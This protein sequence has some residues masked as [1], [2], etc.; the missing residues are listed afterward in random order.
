MRYPRAHA[1]T[2]ILS[3]ALLLAGVLPC[4]A[5]SVSLAPSKRVVINLGETQPAWRYI[6]ADVPDA[7]F[8]STDDTKPFNDGG[9]VKNWISVGLP[10]SAEQYTTFTNETSGGFTASSNTQWY[11]KSFTMDPKYANSKVQVEFE[12]AHTGAQV[13]INGIFVPGTSTINPKATHVVGFLPFIVDLTPYLHFDGSPNLLAVRTS[14]NDSSWFEDPSFSGAFR[15]GQADSGIFRPVY[16][17]ITDRVHIPRNTYSGQGT[18]GTYVATVS[19][20]AASAVIDAQTNVVNEGTADQAVTLTTQIVDANGNIV[21]S[22]QDTKTVPANVGPGLHPQLF[23]ESLTV[24]NPILWYPNNSGY[25]KPYLYKVLHTISIGGTVY[26]A[27]QSPLGIRTITWNSDF[28]II[29]GHPHY[30]WGGSGRYDYPALGTA[31]PEEQQWRDLQ[32][33]AQAGGNLW[34]PGHSSSSPEFVAAADA[35]G[36]MIVQP[37]GD[38]ENGFA[39][40]CTPSCNKGALKKELHRDMIIRDRSNPSILAWEADNGITQEAFAAAL[41][42]LGTLW[43]PVAQ[44]VQADRTPDPQNGTILGCTVEGCEIGLKNDPKN[45]GHPTWGAEYWG[46][47][48]ARGAWDYELAFSAHFMDNWH[49]SV[50]KRAFGIVQWYFAD[51]P[52]ESNVFLEGTP[53][54]QTRSLGSSMVDQN[55]FPKLLYNVYKA[56]WTPYSIQPTV[57]LAHHWNRAGNVRVNAFSNCPYVRLLI[58]NQVQGSDQ[59]PVS[60]STGPLTDFSQNTTQIPTQVHWDVNWAPG[61]VTAQCLDV[62]H[63][64]VPNVQDSKTTAG[65]PDHIELSVVP[66]VVR[67]DGSTF[68]VT[69]N[70]SDAAFVVAKVVDSNGVVVPTATNN[71]TFTVNGPGTYA[72]GTEQ[73]MTPGK[74]VGYHSPGDPELQAEAGLTKIAIRSQFTT[75]TVTVSA[76][77]PGLNPTAASTTS[78]VIQPVAQLQPT[79]TVP[80]IIAQPVA[81]SVTVG[82]PGFFSVT[83]SGAA[84]L[85][86]QWRRNG[87]AIAGANSASYTTPN[88]STADNGAVYSVVVSNS[89]N[90]PATSAGAAL[91]VV[92]AATPVITAQPTAPANVVVGQTVALTVVASGSPTLTYQW[93]KNN[94]PIAGATSATYSTPVLTAADGGSV[95]TV[96]VTNPVNRANPLFSNPVTLSVGAAQ[97]PVITQQPANVAALPGQPATFTVGV[98]GSTPLQFV[99]KRADGT[100]VGINSPA[101]TIPAVQPS[102]IG[103]YTVTVSNIANTVTS[104]PATLSL[105][106]PGVNMALGKA[107]KASSTQDPAGLAAGFAID[108]DP[109]SR[110]GSAYTPVNTAGVDP[111]ATVDNA[112][113]FQVDLG[114]AMRFNRMVLRWDPAYASS[115]RIDVSSDG[116][117]FTPAYTQTAGAGATEDFTFPAVTA[118]Y[119][120]MQGV[121]RATQYGYSLNEMEI[122]NAPGCGGANERYSNASVATDVIDNLSSLQWSRTEYTLTA[123]GSQLTQPLAA[124][125]CANLGKRLPTVDEA[126]AISGTNS[127]SCAFPKAWNTWTSTVYPADTTQDYTVASTG[128]PATHGVATNLP[129]WALCTAGPVAAAPVITAQP[130]ATTVAAGQAATFTVAATTSG[131]APVT[132]EWR[133]NNKPVALTG[134]PSYTTPSTTAAD[135]G[136]SFSVVVTGGNGLTAS[137]NTAALTVAGSVGGGGGGTGAPVIT[138]QPANQTVAAGAAATFTVAATGTGTLSYQWLRGTTVIPGATGIAY[139][140]PATVAADNGA[141]FSV[142]VSASNNTSTTSS[143]AV[144]TIAGTSNTGAGDILAIHAGGP[145]LGG[146]LTDQDFTGGGVGAVSANTIS[147]A[148]VPFAASPA[149][150]QTAREGTFTYTIPNL[151]VGTQYTVRLHFAETW[152]TA[153]Q[154][155]VFNVAINGTVALPNFDI[156]A[157]AGAPNTANVQSLTATAVAVPN[158]TGGQIVIAFT[159]GPVDQ[160]KVDAIEVAPLTPAGPPVTPATGTVLLSINAGG[161]VIKNFVAD[162]DFTGGGVGQTATQPIKTAGVADATDPAVYQS[163]REGVFQYTFTG[164]IPDA[165]YGI[166][167]HFAET[168]FTQPKQR[169]FNVALNGTTVLP[170]FDIVADSGANTAVVKTFTQAAKGG[171]IVVSFTAGTANQPKLDGIELLS[172][173]TN[174]GTAPVITTQPANATVAAGAAATFTVTASG[175]APLTYQWSKNSAAI[176]GATSATYTTPATTSADTGS[177]FQVAVT[178]GGLTT[179]SASAKLT[180]NASTGTAPTITT[181]PASQTVTIGRTAQFHVIANSSGA[182][183]YQWSRNGT[184]IPGATAAT[185]TTPGTAASDGGATYSVVAYAAG[186]PSTPSANAVLT[187]NDANPSVATYARAIGTDLNNN[188]NGTYRDD[189]IFVEVLGSDPANGGALS[190]VG[191]DG[192]VHAASVADNAAANH[193]TGPDGKSY[194]AYAFTLAQSKLL[195]LPVFGSGRVYIS[196]G[197]PMYMPVTPAAPGGQLGYAGPN[198]QNATDPNTNTHF[199]WYEFTSGL[200][201]DGTPNIYINTTQ[202]DQFGLP[203]LLDVWDATAEIN[204]GGVVSK[205]GQTGIQESVAAIDAEYAAETPAAF[206]LTSVSDLRIP[207]PAKDTFVT[208]GANAAYFDN[209]VNSMW[210]YFATNPLTLTLNNGSRQ[211]TGNTTASAF[212]FTEKNLNN[213]AYIGGNYTVGKPTTPQI[214]ACDGV[215]NND[216]NNGNGGPQAGGT[217]AIE[218]QLCAAFNRHV[219][220]TPAQWTAPATFYLA[221]PANFYAQ[222]WHKHSVGG[223]AYGFPYDDASGFSSTIQSS[224]TQHMAFGIGW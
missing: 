177:T 49:T 160:P 199:D 22:T 220:Q 161:P 204:V 86:F 173:A 121:T 12:G 57:S 101:L 114:T 127:A 46:E 179:P 174:N 138:A 223:L 80:V 65:A 165:L 108:G 141:Q 56:A 104:A 136:A 111:N 106:P 32:Q 5:Q 162:Q 3:F 139:T 215:F 203:L 187:V 71:I 155:R 72:G 110:W 66:E 48:S 45:A 92:A 122:Y 210:T 176:A 44:R 47:G 89:F 28:P 201:A 59:V 209:Y 6:A 151:S 91:T 100:T 153:K 27:V 219:V 222:F 207:A 158:G 142:I 24:P 23:D 189:Q 38:G 144:L 10:Y 50:A 40:P 97:G 167:L 163:A 4:V 60:I 55:R 196:L 76:S 62:T 1:L 152:F 212:V 132:Y 41:R 99:W 195:K 112:Q 131:T 216:G 200:N 17:Y 95:Y 88:T 102:D 9:K 171:Q 96:S 129:G 29:N 123:A 81:A 68:A 168:Y 137:S 184:P 124:A 134:L 115:Y 70:G 157:A 191:A 197:S 30:L 218:V 36:I 98:N 214:L 159:Q 186:V 194:P 205:H 34:R 126:L 109:V 18:W 190:W 217:L 25:G 169:S 77:S 150:Y 2:Q 39:D 178:G 120:R 119:V 133:K 146:F 125:Y 172:P 116:T 42:D 193:L 166:R 21:A 140:T 15:F 19:A 107:A 164:L 135:N 87:V 13:Y 52:G 188:T 33:L 149:I 143:A 181:S 156:I 74:P 154:Q 170:D 182:L 43:D 20:S 113:W 192:T 79:A 26:D 93:F 221:A 75:G 54:A 63:T 175:A 85:A 198:P 213:G 11:R 64:P 180:V 145:A 90:P 117:A 58:N 130:A 211:F 224:H 73:V 185:Y 147:T 206:H 8:A 14:K 16:M 202:V 67:P 35:L 7:Q 78:Y 61:T 103:T 94:A 128:P 183:T 82:Y 208:G 51:T 69:A 105:A 53:Y 31:V 84:P 83:A 118:R 37:S 148:N